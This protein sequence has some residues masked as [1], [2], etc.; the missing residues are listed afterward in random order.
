MFGLEDAGPGEEHPGEPAWGDV[1]AVGVRAPLVGVLVQQVQTAGEAEV[2]DL[3]EEVSD[4]GGG[5]LC[6]ASAQV[7]A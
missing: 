3:L 5:I 4:G 6:P 7:L 1:T 2:L